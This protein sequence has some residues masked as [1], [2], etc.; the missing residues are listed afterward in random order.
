MAK[1]Q[2]TTQKQ[3]QTSTRTFKG[4]C[5]REVQ[6]ANSQNRK[7][8]SKADQQWLKS[9]GYKNTGWESVIK[10]YEQI[11]SLQHDSEALQEMSLGSLFLEADRIGN[12]YQTVAEIAE[13]QQK[14]AEADLLISEQI[15]QHFLDTEIEVIDFSAG[16]PPK[17]GKHRA[18]KTR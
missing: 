16:K 9:A 10:L 13:Y 18:K 1:H 2:K 4:M 5:Y 7:G 6:I 17:S 3:A 8:L 12:K 15:D 14:L 11:A